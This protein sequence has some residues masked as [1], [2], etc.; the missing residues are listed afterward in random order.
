MTRTAVHGTRAVALATALACV[1]LLAAAALAAKPKKGAHFTGRM[2]TPPVEGFHAPV[3]FT[4]AG[5]GKTL[6]SFTFGS[7]GCFG[8]GGFRPHVN[9]YTGNS[10]IRAGKLKVSDK[11]KFSGTSTFAYTVAGQTTSTNMTING[12]FPTPKTASGTIT[13]TEKVTGEGLNQKCESPKLSFSAS[14]K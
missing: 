12:S 11:G 7:F 10:L 3:K 1:L 4:V 8:A 9:P 13:F 5:N 14:T 6:E 2:S